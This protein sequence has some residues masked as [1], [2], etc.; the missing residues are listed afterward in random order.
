MPKSVVKRTPA[1]AAYLDALKE[2]N[3]LYSDI[4]RHVLHRASQPDDRRTDVIHASEIVKSGWCMRATY[5]RIVNGP[6]P[7][8]TNFRR[9]NIF[10]E[11][12]RTHDK[13]QNWLAEMRRLEGD[14]LCLAC[15]NFFYARGPERCP[16]CHNVHLRYR[17]IS[18]SAPSLLLYGRA[19]GYVPQDRCLIEIKTMGL[20]GLRYENPGFV[21]RYEE[22]TSRGTV[23]DLDRLWKD[24]RRPLT[25]A[26]KQGT[27]YLHLAREHAGLDVDR[28]VYFYDFKATQ[29]SKCFTVAYDEQL[30]VSLMA[31]AK[32]LADCVT[33][34]VVPDCPVSSSGCRDCLPYAGAAA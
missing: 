6:V 28:M 22:E 1:L 15:D 23:V 18:L 31:S 24:F 34:R 2:H 16:R 27:V 4:T 20:G 12:N 17:E 33:A 29:D 19:D 21:A 8:R 9:E 13:W 32:L 25:P 10:E 7:Q 26:I 5:Y 14:W 30:A 11:G 3:D